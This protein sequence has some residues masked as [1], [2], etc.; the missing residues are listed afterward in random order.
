MWG[1]CEKVD[2]GTTSDEP[3][4]DGTF[5]VSKDTVVWRPGER[6]GS[7][8]APFLASDLSVGS[9]GL[10]VKSNG[11][12]LADCWVEGYIVGYV[13]GTNYK[14]TVF[15]IGNVESNIVLADNS[16][17]TSFQYVV[18]VQLVS[19][20]PY[21]SVRRALNLSDNAWN[22]GRKVMVRGNIAAYMSTTGV[23]NAAEYVFED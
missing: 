5:E 17:E 12:E 18:P 6:D 11:I 13:A 20:T 9:L 22:L 19:N 16:N 14:Q 8:R 21:A 2:I 1:G 23:K 7:H 15:D 10:Y 3:T 4:D